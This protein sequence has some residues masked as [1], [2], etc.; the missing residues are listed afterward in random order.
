MKI[1]IAGLAKNTGKTTFAQTLLL[2]LEN[3]GLGFGI[4]SIGFDGEDVDTVTGLPKP[5]YYLPEGSLVVTS[6]QTLG[7]S[8]AKY[9]KIKEYSS[10][11]TPLGPLVLVE[12]AS[13]GTI[14][15]AGPSTG[16]ALEIV[17]DDLEFLGVDL[18]VV[19]GAFNR[20][21]PFVLLDGVVIT[22]GP[23]RAEDLKIVVEEL[24]V[25]EKVF[26]L[27]KL[28]GFSHSAYPGVFLIHRDGLAKIAG[29]AFIYEEPLP[30]INELR[31]KKDG[32]LVF[33]TFAT[34][35][36]I[37]SLIKSLE[38]EA[39]VFRDPITLL[40]SS[41]SL[42]ALGRM[43]T[44]IE[45]SG[46]STYLLKGPTLLCIAVN[47]CRVGLNP[48]T[49]KFE[50]KCYSPELVLSTIRQA[51]TEVPVVD[52]VYEKSTNLYDLVLRALGS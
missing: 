9:K 13:S 23:S 15:V 45:K 44:Q 7:L 6:K 27:R 17:M 24:K 14:P 48:S 50:K 37:T 30:S 12:T 47:P 40:L 28:G 3:R 36:L 42:L 1:G 11:A 19:D 32:T 38:P 29:G 35:E 22:T 8:T 5:K 33:N 21:G 49:M 51:V 4:T 46:V 26:S 16:D 39:V 52:V 18:A 31:D 41:R 25:V 34:A 20:I 10:I 43:L 2:E